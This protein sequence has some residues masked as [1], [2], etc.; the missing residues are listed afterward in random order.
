M[1]VGRGRASNGNDRRRNYGLANRKIS[2]EERAVRALGRTP[3]QLEFR[4]ENLAEIRTLGE[5]RQRSGYSA[6][7]PARLPRST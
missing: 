5:V 7:G 3:E 1:A 4:S 6:A 2:S